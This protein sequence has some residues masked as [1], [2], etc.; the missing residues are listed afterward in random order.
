MLRSLNRLVGRQLIEANTKSTESIAGASHVRTTSSGWYYSTFLV[1]SFAYLDLVLQDTP[2]DDSEV[3]RSL[4]TLVTQVDN[5][6]DRDDQKLERMHVRVARVRT[7][8]RYLDGQEGREQQRFDLPTRGGIWADRVVPSISVHI[9]REI[10]W[11]LTR[12]QVNRERYVEDIHIEL[13]GADSAISGLSEEEE[14]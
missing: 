3:E 11:I 6:T 5:L 10:T 2:L 1:K 4:R 13:D 12:L 14:T 8:L 9:E 7:F